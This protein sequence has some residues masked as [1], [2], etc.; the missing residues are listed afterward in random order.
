[1]A[2]ALLAGVAWAADE[3][4]N[5]EPPLAD[6]RKLIGDWEVT[7]FKIKGMALPFPNDAKLVISFNKNGTVSTGGGF[8][9]GKDGKWKI[10]PKKSPRHLDMI[11]GNMTTGMIYKLEKDVLTI[12]G[13]EGNGGARPKDFASAEVSMVLKR[14]TKK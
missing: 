6:S 12:A 8:G 14:K 13:A 3:D 7:E 9:G 11:D 4:D 10:D 1:M 2:L 5:P